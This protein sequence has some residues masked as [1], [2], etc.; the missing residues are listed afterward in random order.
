M[1]EGA[2]GVAE[3]LKD[4]ARAARESIKKTAGEVTNAVIDTVL[5]EAEDLYEKQ[6]DRAV[7]RVSSIGKIAKQT[8]H[9]LHAV[10]A[11]KFADYV[12]EASRRV[13]EA[14]DYLE[15]R[16]LTE[17]LQDAGEVVR[18]NRGITM[19]TLFV[20]GFAVARFLKSS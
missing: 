17:M 18:R 13:D 15:E 20:A 14:G 4:G 5:E 9:A 2:S 12:D 8:A 3:K 7:S 1:D 11:D 10:K 19:G 16:T 6:K